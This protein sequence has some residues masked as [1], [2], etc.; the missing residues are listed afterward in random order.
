MGRSLPTFDTQNMTLPR[1]PVPDQPSS[2]PMLRRLDMAAVTH[3]VRRVSGHRGAVKQPPMVFWPTSEVTVCVA[4]VALL[5]ARGHQ[6]A[7]ADA[8]KEP[9]RCSV[10]TDRGGAVSSARLWVSNTQHHAYLTKK[11]MNRAAWIAACHQFVFV[12]TKIC[13]WWWACTPAPTDRCVP[14]GARTASD[15]ELDSASPATCKISSDA[16]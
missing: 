16:L 8:A 15:S 1:L 3:V 11:C 12:I 6:A 9:S 7:A 10:C 4:G 13:S 2:D 5:A 14:I